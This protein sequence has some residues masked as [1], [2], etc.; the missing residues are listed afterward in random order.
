MRPP[1]AEVELVVRAGKVVSGGDSEDVIRSGR[2]FSDEDSE[3]VVVSLAVED[4]FVVSALSDVLDGAAVEVADGEDL[5]SADK[6][7]NLGA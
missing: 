3:E 4:P 1:S 5:L 7:G 2:L 6:A